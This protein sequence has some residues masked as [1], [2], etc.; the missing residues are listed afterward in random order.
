MEKQKRS[1]ERFTNPCEN[2]GTPVTRTRGNIKP[3]TFCSVECYRTSDY[4]R[5]TVKAANA[6]RNPVP[7][8]IVKPCEECGADVSRPRSQYRNRT[9]CSVDCRTRNRAK[10]SARQRTSH[11]YI[12]IFI[13]RQGSGSD[14]SGHILEHRKVMQDWLGRALLPSENVHH[15]NGIRDDNRLENLELWS[16]SQPAGQRVRDKLRWAAEFQK[17]YR[18]TPMQE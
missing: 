3:H 10:N 4:H 15:K 18:D 9:F 11:G 14:K 5:E 6:K 12:R 17:L 7:A 8:T 2:C 16:S 1:R 13:G